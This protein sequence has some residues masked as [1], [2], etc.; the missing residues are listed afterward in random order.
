MIS[1]LGP[2]HREGC[3]AVVATLPAWFGYEGALADVGRAV[4][5][6]SGFVALDDGEVVGFVTTTEAYLETT[7][8]TYL[9]VRAADRRRGL[10][11]ALV[12]AVVEVARAAGVQSICLLT[13]GPSANSAHYAETVAFYQALGFWRTK[14]L[15]LTSWGGAPT[16]VMTA[17]LAALG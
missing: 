4:G 14:E 10:G 12:A 5:E 11:R 2:E 3:V 7:E 8:I 9:A 6:Q 16:L 13:L 15:Y 1:A 17:P